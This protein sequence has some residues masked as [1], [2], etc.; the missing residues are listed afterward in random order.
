MIYITGDCHGD[1][2]RF[3]KPVFPDQTEMTKDDYVIVCG[4]FG[5]WDDSKE[6]RWWLDWLDNKPFTTLFVDGNHENFD[7]LYSDEFQVVDFNGGKVH[8]IRDSV[9]HLMRGYIFNICDKKIFTFGGARSHDIF[10]GILDRKDFSN[11]EAF[12]KTIKE[13]RKQGKAFRI[14]HISWWEQELP[15]Q[16]EMDFGLKTLRQSN[17][18]V[19]FIVSHCCPQRIA[20]VYS[21]G[22]FKPDVLTQYFNVIDDTVNFSKWYF[23]HYHDNVSIFDKYEMRYKEI[24]RVV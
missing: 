2:I 22:V 4:D 15:D 17:N 14:N 24:E 23:G 7:R 3:S 11:N 12:K 18:Q 19:D 20:S 6:E 9:L 16:E 10:N 13:W 8:Q 1:Y 5:I 21:N